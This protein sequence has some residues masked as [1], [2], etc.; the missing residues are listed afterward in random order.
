MPRYPAGHRESDIHHL[1]AVL[2]ELTA[3]P[4]R[5]ET[6]RLSA[7]LNSM[8]RSWAL[9]MLC[10]RLSGSQSRLTL[11]GSPRSILP[12][13]FDMLKP[14]PKG[15]SQ[16][17]KDIERCTGSEASPLTHNLD[18]CTIAGVFRSR[19]RLTHRTRNK[20]R[21]QRWCGERSRSSHRSASTPLKTAT[22]IRAG[23]MCNRRSYGSLRPAC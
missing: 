9:S 12:Y 1:Q 15:S 7:A 21:D 20:G 3:Y 17:D 10:G 6:A 11:I 22:F 8:R 5:L 4:S 18:L 14:K 23:G 2:I 16:I 13:N 19:H